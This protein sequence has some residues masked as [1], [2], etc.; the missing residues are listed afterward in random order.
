MSHASARGIALL[1][2]TFAVGTLAGVAVQRTVTRHASQS[3][4]FRLQSPDMLNGLGLTREQR[5]AADAILERSSPRSEAVM[6][7]MAPRL[8]AIADSVN[9]ELGVILT[10]AQRTKLDSMTH[11]AVIVL[12]KKNAE[13]HERIDTILKR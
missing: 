13:G 11:G 12:K 1:I 6:L 7:E 8:A 4:R 5:H 2:L 10:P 3:M 9:A